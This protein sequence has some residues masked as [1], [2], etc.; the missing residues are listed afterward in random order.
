MWLR[1]SSRTSAPPS[2]PG[3]LIAIKVPPPPVRSPATWVSDTSTFVTLCWLTRFSNVEKA[4][5]LPPVPE[6]PRNRYTTNRKPRA[7]R[8]PARIRRPLSAPGPPV[9]PPPRSKPGQRFRRW[10]RPSFAMRSGLSSHPIGEADT[11]GLENGV[12]ASRALSSVRGHHAG[13]AGTRARAGGPGPAF[14]PS[15]RCR[16]W[17][18]GCGDGPAGRR[19]DAPPV[20]IGSV[21][22]RGGGAG[23]HPRGARPGRRVLHQPVPAL[24][25]A[26]GR[27]RGHPRV[28]GRRGGPRYGGAGRGPTL[29]RTVSRGRRA[30]GAPLRL[31]RRDL[32]ARIRDRVAP[33]LRARAAPGVRPLR[34]RY[35][36]GLRLAPQ[37]AGRGPRSPPPDRD[38]RGVDGRGGG[39]A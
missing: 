19:R 11:K 27:H 22:P 21:R 14:A 9:P 39:A 18:A 13:P 17:P 1:W 5:S 8:R 10:L 26:H 15:G 31:G 2:S 37:A 32:P 28:R 6:S 38:Q 4:I 34:G 29:G 20:L 12:F 16:G 30:V 7:S 3:G 24:R 36:P 23:R 25:P 35:R 33:R